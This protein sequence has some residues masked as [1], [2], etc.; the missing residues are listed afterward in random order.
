MHQKSLGKFF[1]R[2][3]GELIDALFVGLGVILVVLLYFL[4]VMFEDE[5]SVE[6]LILGPFRG[7]L[8]FPEFEGVG[9]CG[10]LKVVG[11]EGEC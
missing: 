2:V 4:N 7:E 10:F 5:L 3:N 8:L 11:E 1:L 6:F 9:R